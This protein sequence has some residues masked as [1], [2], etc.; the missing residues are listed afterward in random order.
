MFH[1]CGDSQILNL[2]T[3]RPQPTKREGRPSFRQSRSSIELSFVALGNCK[4]YHCCWLRTATSCVLFVKKIRPNPNPWSWARSRLKVSILNRTKSWKYRESKHT[5]DLLRNADLFHFCSHHLRAQQ[6]RRSDQNILHKSWN[7][8]IHAVW[9]IESSQRGRRD[10]RPFSLN[11]LRTK[12][13]PITLCP[14]IL[15]SDERIK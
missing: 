14:S 10:V 11:Q 2:I 6:R 15:C 7:N 1:R 8:Q 3:Q 12:A 5:I 9:F 4:V 13:I